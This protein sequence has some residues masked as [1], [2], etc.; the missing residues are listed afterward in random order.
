MTSRGRLV[1]FTLVELLVVIT[2]IAVLAALFL[3]AL[4]AAR[5]TGRRIVCL[6]NQRQIYVGANVSVDDSSGWLPPG[7]NPSS[8][9]VPTTSGGSG[10]WGVYSIF[11]T[12]YLGLSISNFSGAN[13]FTRPVGILWCPSGNR[14]EYTR[15]KASDPTAYS[16]K[17]WQCS[18]DYALS[19]M[20]LC[21][22]STPRMPARAELI[23][24]FRPYG[25]PRVFS[26]DI[27]HSNPTND[28]AHFFERSPHKNPADGIAD[29][30]NVVATDGSGEW[31]P[32]SKCT[33][34]GGNRPGGVWQY[35]VTWTS[36]VLP[37]RYEVLFNDNNYTF[38]WTNSVYG[39]MN[40]LSSSTV[41]YPTLSMYST[42]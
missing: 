41:S 42:W 4:R 5:E 21:D 18:T 8:G 9:D 30:L 2:I 33:L 32:R 15:R 13:Y 6:S 3:P 17:N 25:R 35:Y 23:W 29:G 28:W 19:G 16:M 26:M 14:L 12:R 36:V 7:S 10:C 37:T 31:Q 38:N 24:N 20:T 34:Y 22:D 40:G 39:A 27:A 1:G 11:W